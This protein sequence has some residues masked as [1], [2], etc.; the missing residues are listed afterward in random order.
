MGRNDVNGFIDTGAVS[1]V[2]GND[3]GAR[4]RRKRFCSF[5]YKDKNEHNTQK[6]ERGR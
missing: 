2:V 3:I 4:Y 6:V 5:K 1:G